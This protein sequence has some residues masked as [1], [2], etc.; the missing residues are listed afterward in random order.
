MEIDGSAEAYWVIRSF[1]LIVGHGGDTMT[2]QLAAIAI[3]STR[4]EGPC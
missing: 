3:S 1:A 4:C 2:G